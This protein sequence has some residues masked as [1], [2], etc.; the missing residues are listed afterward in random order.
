MTGAKLMTELS[1]ARTERG[2]GRL[3]LERVPYP[4]D[5]ALKALAPFD[6]LILV[7]AVPPVGFFAYPGKPSRQYKDGAGLHVLSRVEQN[8]EAALAGAG[9]RARRAARRRFPATARSRPS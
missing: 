1:N 3:P 4:T 6:H 8:P 2:Q 7:N 9:G 5:A